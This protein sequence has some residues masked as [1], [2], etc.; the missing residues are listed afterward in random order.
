MRKHHVLGI[1]TVLLVAFGAK[2]IFFPVPVA[3]AFSFSAG[4]SMDVSRM[5]EN[6]VLPEQPLRDMTFVQ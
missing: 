2:L 1:V 5:H 6:K 3:T 4:P